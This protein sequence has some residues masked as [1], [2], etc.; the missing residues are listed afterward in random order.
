MLVVF[1]FTYLGKSEMARVSGF[2]FPFILV[3]AALYLQ[4]TADETQSCLA[5][6]IST[7]LLLA[8]TWMME[9]LLYMY[10]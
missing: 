10:W 9:T 4:R 3:P 7:M 5:P 6:D 1:N 2:Y 8:Q